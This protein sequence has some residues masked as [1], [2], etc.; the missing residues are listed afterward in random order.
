[1]EISG[2]KRSMRVMRKSDGRDGQ[3]DYEILK[4]ITIIAIQQLIQCEH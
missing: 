4:S 3:I 1:M 2:E